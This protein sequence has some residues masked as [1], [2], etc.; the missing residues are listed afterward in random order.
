[1]RPF[2]KDEKENKVENSEKETPE[3]QKE[4]IPE[5]PNKNAK[6]HSSKKDFL[7]KIFEEEEA[8]NNCQQCPNCFQIVE[9]VSQN[10]KRKQKMMKCSC[11]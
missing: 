11:K 4:E 3:D 9:Q 8:R 10:R 1:M 7:T 2:P 5:M 6:W